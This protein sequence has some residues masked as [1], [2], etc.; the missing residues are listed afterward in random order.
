[1]MPYR[2]TSALPYM[3]PYLCCQGTSYLIHFILYRQPSFSKSPIISTKSTISYSVPIAF[4]LYEFLMCWLGFFE[5]DP[6]SILRAQSISMLWATLCNLR[7]FT[8][9]TPKLAIFVKHPS[10]NFINICFF[11]HRGQLALL[12]SRTPLNQLVSGSRL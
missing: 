4:L 7:K 2:I 1:M 11:S 12:C 10:L 8:L 3:P 6:L 9:Y 5:G